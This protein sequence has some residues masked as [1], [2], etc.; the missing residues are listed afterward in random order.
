MNFQKMPKRNRNK[1]Q[2]VIKQESRIGSRVRR[3]LRKAKRNWE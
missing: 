2:V 1:G 3:E